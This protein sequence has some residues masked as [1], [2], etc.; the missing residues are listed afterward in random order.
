MLARDAR[1]AQRE[2]RP[3]RV[4]H[5][6]HARLEPPPVFVVDGESTKTLEPAAH[7]GM[8]DRHALEVQGDQ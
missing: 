5:R 4:P 2:H 8:V 1:L 3:C 6:R 7:D